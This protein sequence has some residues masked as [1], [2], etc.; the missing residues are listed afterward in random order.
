MS[1][2]VPNKY[3]FR[4]NR[5]PLS[6]DD[7]I[8]N[9]GAFYVPFE[10]RE[11]KCIAS[12]GMGWEHISIS[13]PTRCPNW[14]EMCFIKELFWDGEDTVVQYH[15]PESQYVNNYPFCLHLWRP[16]KEKMPLP[17]NIMV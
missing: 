11:L 13:L 5:H 12:D 7:S 1:F 4:N 17:P 16:I 3:R 8:E 6:S 10:N 15:P 14:K 2:H 9:N